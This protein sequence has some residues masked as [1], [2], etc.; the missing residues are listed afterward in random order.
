MTEAGGALLSF[1]FARWKSTIAQALGQLLLPYG[2]FPAEHLWFLRSM[3]LPVF[4]DSNGHMEHLP[5]AGT[6]S[7]VQTVIQGSQVYVYGIQY[8]EVSFAPHHLD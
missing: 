4:W 8:A 2:H 7:V 5:I 6:P 1:R 3:A